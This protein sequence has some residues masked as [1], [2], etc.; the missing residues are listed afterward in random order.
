MLPR[1][2]VDEESSSDEDRS[3]DGSHVQH[4]RPVPRLV[5]Q[6]TSEEDESEPDVKPVITKR[7]S[8]AENPLAKRP[9]VDNQ[10]F[11]ARLPKLDLVSLPDK[12]LAPRELEVLM[13]ASAMEARCGQPACSCYVYSRLLV[14]VRLARC[15][16]H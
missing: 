8:S 2:D 3:S 10:Y 12:T 15:V 7:S 9:R 4:A 6:E 5:R 14:S 16:P 11:V 13:C 1:R